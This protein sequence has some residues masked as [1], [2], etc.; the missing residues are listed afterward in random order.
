MHGATTGG[1][2]SWARGRVRGGAGQPGLDGRSGVLPRPDERT[3]L[4]MALADG[5]GRWLTSTAVYLIVKALFVPAAEARQ[6]GDPA[7]AAT[8]RRASTHWLRPRASPPEARGGCQTAPAHPVS[9]HA[10][11]ATARRLR[12]FQVMG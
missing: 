9:S 12:Q 5:R 2:R 6:A 11:S 10:K 3:P 7:G 1:A 4:V 8:L